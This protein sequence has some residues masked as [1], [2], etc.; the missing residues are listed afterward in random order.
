MQ[1]FDYQKSKHK[2]QILKRLYIP[3]ALFVCSC[4]YLVWI[5]ERYSWQ[6]IEFMLR[7]SL[8]VIGPLSLI[9]LTLY[10]LHYWINQFRQVQFPTLEIHTDN[11]CLKDGN[12]HET[13]YFDDMHSIRL[14][15]AGTTREDIQIILNSGQS[16]VIHSN[17]P[18]D[19]IKPLLNQ[20]LECKL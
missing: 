17:F 1:H 4:A 11:L 3:L 15:K 18:I 12:V 10:S 2:I 5:L 13:V 8:I 7:T 16:I 20:Y 6:Q 14:R 9:S 19:S